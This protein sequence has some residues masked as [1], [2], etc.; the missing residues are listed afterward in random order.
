VERGPK[1]IGFDFFEEYCGG[2][3]TSARDFA[4]APSSGAGVVTWKG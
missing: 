3:P 2:C 1:N 4:H